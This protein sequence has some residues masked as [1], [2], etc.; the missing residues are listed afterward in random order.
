[1][2]EILADAKKSSEEGALLPSYKF[3]EPII[4]NTSGEVEMIVWSRVWSR[5][6]SVINLCSGIID[7]KIYSRQE[8]LPE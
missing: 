1:M 6:F 4:D 7:A 8:S 5:V 3:H 2:D